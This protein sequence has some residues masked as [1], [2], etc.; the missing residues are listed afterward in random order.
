M[1]TEHRETRDG[2]GAIGISKA[3]RQAIY[4]ARG[5]AKPMLI[6]GVPI[7][8]LHLT[9]WCTHAICAIRSREGVATNMVDRRDLV[10][11]RNASDHRLNVPTTA[12]RNP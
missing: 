12:G 7:A 1:T 11:T 8:P 5:C 10:V 6:Y 4:A 3:E 9:L 2:E